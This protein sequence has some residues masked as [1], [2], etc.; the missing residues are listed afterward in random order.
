MEAF[1]IILNGNEYHVEPGL[2]QGFY[3]VNCGS[4]AGMLGKSENEQWELTL[5]TSD[6]LDISAAEL[7]EVV[8][9]YMAN[10]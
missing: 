3:S 10:N 1:N 2:H 9:K 5:Q 7:G 6:A 8:E 4:R